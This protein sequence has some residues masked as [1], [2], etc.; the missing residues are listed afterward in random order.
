MY[1]FLN[2][3]ILFNF[4]FFYA[5]VHPLS[6]LHELLITLFTRQILSFLIIYTITNNQGQIFVTLCNVENF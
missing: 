5:C 3:R 1:L 6:F 4:V 2:R